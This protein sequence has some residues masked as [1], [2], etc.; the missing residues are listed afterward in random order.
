MITRGKIDEIISEDLFPAGFIAAIVNYYFDAE[1]VSGKAAKRA[2]KR[3]DLKSMVL[4]N[5]YRTT[6]YYYYK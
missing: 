2:L 4:F 5:K 1:N 3:K 6:I